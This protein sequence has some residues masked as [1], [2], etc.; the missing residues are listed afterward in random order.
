MTTRSLNP[1]ILYVIF[2]MVM[3]LQVRTASTFAAHLYL[4]ELNAV[5][6]YWQSWC[7]TL[8]CT[9]YAVV[10]TSHYCKNFNLKIIIVQ[11]ECQNK[12]V[13]IRKKKLTSRRKLKK[14]ISLKFWF[15]F[16]V[17][18]VWFFYSGWLTWWK[19][20]VMCHATWVTACGREGQRVLYKQDPNLTCSCWPQNLL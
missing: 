18:Q 19:Q 16:S 13:T 6:R 10:E 7:C 12:W 4:Y 20:L 14:I 15:T 3:V 11:H 17:V 9:F 1:N 8:S 5:E 2:K